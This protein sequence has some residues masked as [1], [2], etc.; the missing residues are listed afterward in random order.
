M[1]VLGQFRISLFHQ[2][3]KPQTARN[4]NCKAMGERTPA[5]RTLWK[6]EKPRQRPEQRGFDLTNKGILCTKAI[7]AGYAMLSNAKPFDSWWLHIPVILSYSIKRHGKRGYDSPRDS[8][9][10]Q[11]I[12][13]WDSHDTALG[14]KILV[15]PLFTPRWLAVVFKVCVSFR[16]SHRYWFIPFCRVVTNSYVV[17]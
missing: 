15:P 17:L 13:G 7:S 3:T 14:V 1:Q 4:R 6:K 12:Q 16:W 5:P 9:I 2:Q 11:L 8:E 10:W